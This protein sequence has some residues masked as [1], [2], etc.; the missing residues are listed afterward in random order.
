[1]SALGARPS[2]FDI[3]AQ[4]VETRTG[5]PSRRVRG[6]HDGEREDVAVARSNVMLVARIHRKVDARTK[7][8]E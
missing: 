8:V 4:F 5:E 7:P 6:A 3:A 2:L 1:V